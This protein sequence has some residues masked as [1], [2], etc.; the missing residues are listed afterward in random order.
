MAYRHRKTE[1]GKI[2]QPRDNKGLNA[3]SKSTLAEKCNERVRWYLIAVEPGVFLRD[4]AL[5]QAHF[6]K[7]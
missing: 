6:H 5:Q 1:T 4:I 7:K 3:F 2:T